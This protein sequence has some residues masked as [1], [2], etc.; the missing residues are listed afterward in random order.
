MERSDPDAKT[1][2]PQRAGACPGHTPERDGLT[3]KVRTNG[4]RAAGTRR[5]KLG[6]ALVQGPNTV[7]IAKVAVR[8]G[9][10]RKGVRK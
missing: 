7:I 9:S 6:L 4:D 1:G 8:A 10:E 2:D 3:A 5:R